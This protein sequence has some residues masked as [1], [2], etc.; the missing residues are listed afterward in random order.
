M[1]C[2]VSYKGQY[3]K[4][5]DDVIHI[6]IMTSIVDIFIFL[7]ITYNSISEN[8]I[9]KREVWQKMENPIH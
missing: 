9:L 2:R 1:L 5:T 7:K 6:D 8:Q 3:I 4:L